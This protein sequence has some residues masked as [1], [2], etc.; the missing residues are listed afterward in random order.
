MIVEDF[1]FGEIYDLTYSLAERSDLD[2]IFQILGGG[3]ELSSFFLVWGQV[4]YYAQRMLTFAKALWWSVEDDPLVLDLDGDGIETISFSRSGAHF[5]LDGDDFAPKTGWLSGD[6]G[7][8]VMDIDGDGK[9]RDITEMF[10][11]PGGSSF[12]QLRELDDN[13]DGAIDEADAAFG[14]LQIWRDIDGDAKTDDGEPFSLAEL[15]IASIGAEGAAL[16]QATPQGHLL[17]EQAAFTRTDGTIG[18]VYELIFESDT[19]RSKF[20]GD[21]RSAGAARS[22]RPGAGR[23]GAVHRAKRCADADPRGGRGW[24]GGRA[25]SCDLGRGYGGRAG[26]S[27]ARLRR[28]IDRP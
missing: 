23:L 16:D 24:R 17:R 10:G 12:A 8:L 21:A 13:G 28:A 14:D 11:A 2:I 5:D 15:G 20:N 22:G 19:T 6:D 9:I 7:F 3:I 18:A 25:R 26:G 4:I 27:C 1:D